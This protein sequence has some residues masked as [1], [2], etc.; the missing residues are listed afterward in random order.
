MD[1]VDAA[2]QQL[3]AV[4]AK[5]RS[6]DITEDEWRRALIEIRANNAAFQSDYVVSGQHWSRSFP[7]ATAD[8]M[9]LQL[10]FDEREVDDV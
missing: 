7:D 9:V 1:G 8:A 4:T 10:P 6:V 3:M 2:T 5:T